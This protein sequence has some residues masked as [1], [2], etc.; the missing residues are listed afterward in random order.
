MQ[1]YFDARAE[2]W[3]ESERAEVHQQGIEAAQEI[4]DALET[5]WE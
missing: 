4:A 2:E 3:Q 1:D 5:V